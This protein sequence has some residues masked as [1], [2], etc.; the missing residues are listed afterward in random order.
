MVLEIMIA[1]MLNNPDALPQKSINEEVIKALSPKSNVS[2][3]LS[4]EKFKEICEKPIS[5][6]VKEF[7]D[8]KFP[9]ETKNINLDAARKLE[10]FYKS[11][12]TGGLDGDYMKEKQ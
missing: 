9:D 4:E 5:E 1:S 8:K 6:I 10:D 11:G 3:N 7:Y 12:E 2:L